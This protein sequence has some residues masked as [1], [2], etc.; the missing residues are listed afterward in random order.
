M[1]NTKRFTSFIAEGA[2]SFFPTIAP[3]VAAYQK[4][5]SKRLIFG[6]LGEPREEPNPRVRA[7]LA[8]VA[9]DTKKY[10]RAHHYGPMAGLEKMRE[11]IAGHFERRGF[12]GRQKIDPNQV[13]ITVSCKMALNILSLLLIE[14][15]DKCALFGPTYP[16]HAAG[17]S[18]ARGRIVCIP[19]R[20]KNGWS[21][22]SEE[23]RIIL[24]KEKPKFLV[25]CD[26]QNPTGGVL[27][28]KARQVIVEYVARYKALVF[29][30]TIYHD[31]VYTK[32]YCP[33]SS[34]PE[35]AEQVFIVDGASKNQ[36]ATGWRLGIIILPPRVYKEL[37]PKVLTLQ[38]T[39]YSCPPTPLAEAI[40]PGFEK[41]GDAWIE[42]NRAEYMKRRDVVARGVN[43][44]K[45]ITCATPLGAFYSMWNIKKTGK[46][47][48]EFACL[49]ARRA[50]VT[51]LPAKYFGGSTFD[52][53]GK[54]L[55]PDAED[56]VRYSY[57]GSLDDQRE[58]MR[59]L[60]KIVV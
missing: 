49:L 24:H 2:H 36:A 30:D 58:A 27:T 59:R 52:W 46:T 15:G 41:A 17:P 37:L 6:H 7:C 14:E 44:L 60:E 34:Y 5:T 13:V 19:V 40:V 35:I 10:P 56:Y 32:D 1:Q 51:V 54:S 31:H 26:P 12:Y 28:K 39:F 4:E 20:E 9:L 43:M 22:D 16:G 11:A 45:S 33:L 8:Q 25:L 23:M 50:G 3:L 42:R 48:D 47:P 55:F 38:N 21:P 18:M 53:H 57:V 29:E